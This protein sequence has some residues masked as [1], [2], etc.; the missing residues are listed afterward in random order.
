MTKN[1]KPAGQ[2]REEEVCTHYYVNRLPRSAVRRKKK[3]SEGKVFEHKRT[4]G[5]LGVGWGKTKRTLLGDMGGVTNIVGSGQ[6]R[7]ASE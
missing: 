6:K 1:I 3:T 4:L 7:P 2:R 5:Q